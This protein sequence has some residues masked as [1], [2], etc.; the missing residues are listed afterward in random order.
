MKW[1]E[2]DG[3][4]CAGFYGGVGGLGKDKMEWVRTTRSGLG[5]VG[6]GWRTTFSG[7]ERLGEGWGELE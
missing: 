4:Q 6:V 2:Q 7:S 1:V 5:R 3:F